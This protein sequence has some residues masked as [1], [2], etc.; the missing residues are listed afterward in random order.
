MSVPV[1]LPQGWTLAKIGQ[2]VSIDGLFCDGDWV[3][4]KDQNPQGDVRLIQLADIGNGIYRNRSNRFLTSEKAQE[5]GCTYLSAGDV[6]VARMPDP[7]GRACI[8]PG[9]SR[10]SVTAV[11][12]CIIRTGQEGAFSRWLVQ[13]INSPAFR[14]DIRSLQRGTTR[15]RISRQNLSR[16]LLPVPPLPEQH[17]IVAKIEEL[18]TRLDAAVEALKTAQKQLKAYRQAVLRD[19]F[20]GRLTA[21]WREEQLKDPNSLLQKEPASILLE[22]IREEMQK[23]KQRR[24]LPHIVRSELPEIPTAWEWAYLSELGS[25]NRGKSKH[26]PRNAAFL[27]GGSYPFIQTGEIR[28]AEVFI[29][30]YS[31][32]YSEQGLAQSRLWEAGTLCITIAANIA[33]TAILGIR[34]CFP[35]SVVGFIPKEKA[36][37]AKFIH[38]FFRTIKNQLEA[39]APA[40]AQKNINLST[41]DEVIVP[42][43]SRIEQ[44]QIVEEIERRFSLA[45]AAEK[46]IERSLKEA[47]RLRQSILK[48]AFEGK[49]VPQDPS[50]E[51]AEK[52]L[53]R[54]K[55]ER[56]RL[57][58]D[59]ST[60]K[61]KR[62][63]ARK[64]K[65]RIS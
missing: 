23:T 17:R 19:A 16:L 40:T 2:L 45:D 34:A 58:I 50:D 8:F 36:C 63:P 41:L 39:F 30:D 21:E 37:T 44:N 1:E 35:D 27:F 29:R 7:L 65:E 33:D 60:R 26:R 9:D 48:H 11:D 15:K 52:L 31:Q 12:V 3:E 13:S 57:G 28:A 32:T 62:S 10:R 55:A 18:F 47:E 4:S 14:R 38:Y 24:E 53:E 42:F 43:S 22:R 59:K 61:R 56:E 6:L 20:T 49:L 25:L 54:I 5:L 46:T 51:P 64:R